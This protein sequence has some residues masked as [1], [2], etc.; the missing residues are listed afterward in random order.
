VTG[1]AGDT[2]VEPIVNLRDARLIELYL[3]Y[4]S[5]YR[6]QELVVRPASTEAH[7]PAPDPDVGRGSGV[8]ADDG[9]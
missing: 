4:C 3:H 7:V 6:D 5:A 8:A 1:D 9:A 2:T